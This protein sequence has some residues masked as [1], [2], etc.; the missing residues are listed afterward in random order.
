MY[1]ERCKGGRMGNKF[2]FNL[3]V[4]SVCLLF[5]A[6]FAGKSDAGEP[7]D[8]VKKTVDT[9]IQILN[10]NE[11]R[12]PE[13]LDERRSKI[14]EAVERSF[15]FEEMA[16]RSLA[17]HW[18]DRTPQEKTEF[19]SLF[20]D[21]LEDVYIRKIERYED[22]KVIYTDEKADGPYATVKTIVATAKG[23]EIPVAYKIF[24]KDQKWEVYD[25][26]I[27]GVSLVN[28]YRSQ[29]NQIIRSGS[30]EELVIKLKKKVQ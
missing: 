27:E 9:V 2:I 3:F 23:T 19:V 20:S 11:L 25:I 15:D 30:Y 22:E 17:L 14:R 1:L 21:F 12:K 5:S 7:T 13:R 26:V 28:N 8:Q 6:F 18:K 4:F 24:K 29:F 16:K 10:D